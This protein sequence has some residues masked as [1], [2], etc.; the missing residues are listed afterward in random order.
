METNKWLIKLP[1]ITKPCI[2][3]CANYYMYWEFKLFEIDED[4]RLLQDDEW[5]G[6]IE[7]LH[8]DLFMII[9]LPKKQTQ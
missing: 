9:D 6:E 7:D 1:E 4:L 8:G 3:I 5:W 2:I